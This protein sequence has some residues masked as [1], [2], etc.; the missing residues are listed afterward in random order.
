MGSQG[1]ATSGG[2]WDLDEPLPAWPRRL[3]RAGAVAGIWAVSALPVVLGWQRCPVATFWHRP[4]PGCGLTRALEL[5]AAGNVDASLRMHPLA[6]PVLVAGSL[7]ALS[8]V[9]AT[10]AAGSPIRTYRS[11]FGRFAV[12]FAIAVYGAALVLWVL[13]WFGHFGGAVPV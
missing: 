9:W 1:S 5:L 13:R 12:A 8:T 10:F 6:L 4:C 3:G 7:L 2:F 11:R